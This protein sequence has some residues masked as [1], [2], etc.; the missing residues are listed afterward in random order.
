MVGCMWAKHQEYIA[1]RSATARGEV[2]SHNRVGGLQI[3]YVCLLGVGAVCVEP[4]G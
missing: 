4:V 3:G 1:C 2:A